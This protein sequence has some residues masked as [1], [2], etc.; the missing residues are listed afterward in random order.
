MAIGV[1]RATLWVLNKKHSH[2]RIISCDSGKYVIQFQNEKF[3]VIEF[4]IKPEDLIALFEQD[5]FMEVKTCV[6][7]QD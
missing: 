1:E 6:G 5:E 3:D 7:S 2:V 4:E